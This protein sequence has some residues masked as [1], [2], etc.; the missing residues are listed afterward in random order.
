MFEISSI[1]EQLELLYSSYKIA[2]DGKSFIEW[3]A[4]DWRVFDETKVSRE[5]QLGLISDALGPTFPI[6]VPMQPIS[7]ELQQPLAKWDELKTELKEKNRYFFDQSLIDMDRLSDLLDFL[8][9][10]DL[11][12]RWY[13][14]RITENIDGFE[15]SDMGAP[16]GRL[17]SHG[18]ANPP[19]IPYLYL[20]SAAETS[21]SEV[22]PHTGEKICIAT[23]EI[24]G[25]I[26][27]VDLRDPRGYVSPFILDDTFSIAQLRNDIPFIERL[28]EE[29]TRPI[30]PKGAAIE[31]VPTQ[32]LCEFIK[33]RGY[34]GVVYRSAISEGFNFALFDPSRARALSTQVFNIESVRVQIG[35]VG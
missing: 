4:S 27:A 28:G 14:G 30:V 7:P 2:K 18:R 11:P 26:T 12:G 33:K 3:M 16:P 32:F 34:D 19:G 9:T 25:P 29:L 15:L 35:N 5:D 22:R 8:L 6:D 1:T 24:D 23:F 10:S 21:A 13:R 31:Y 20:A 17:A